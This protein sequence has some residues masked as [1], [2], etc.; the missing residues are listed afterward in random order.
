[1]FDIGSNAWTQNIPSIS[2]DTVA[3]DIVNVVIIIRISNLSR[4]GS[5]LDVLAARQRVNTNWVVKEIDENQ[6]NADSIVHITTHTWVGLSLTDKTFQ[7]QPNAVILEFKK[8]NHFIQLQNST[9]LFS[10]MQHV[11]FFTSIK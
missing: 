3:N 9:I 8:P 5:V 10:A 6:A 2:I 4:C 1:M 11:S 7:M